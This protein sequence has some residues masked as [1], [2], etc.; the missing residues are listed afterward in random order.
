MPDG[1]ERTL[2]TAISSGGTP[3]QV[4]DMMVA[5]ATDHF[6]RDGGHILD[7]INKSFELLETDRLGT[8][9]VK[10]YRR[11]PVVSR[12]HRVQKNRN[13]WR[14]PNRFLFPLLND[15]FEELEALMTEGAGK[16][17]EGAEQLVEVLLGDDPF[18]TVEATQVG[19]Q[20]RSNTDRIDADACLCGGDADRP[21]FS[22]EKMSSGDWIA[23]LHTYTYANAL[24][25]CAKAWPH[26]WNLPAAFFMARW[27]STLN[28]WFNMPAAR[29]PQHRRETDTL[30]NRL[31]MKLLD[32]FVDLLNTQ[33]RADEAG[34]YLYRYL[35]LGHPRAAIIQKLGHILLRED[36]EFHSFQMLEAALHQMEETG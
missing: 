19:V 1:A 16:Q 36:A 13:R 26:R 24:H 31:R 29:L 9:G 25:Q 6:Y 22:H 33:A 32:G 10:F 2:L 23:V 17:W 4:C 27:Q 12:G 11:S 21:R 8:R 15:S 35:S 18:A 5:A 28:R 3:A 7:F 30:P 14:S 34:M 20:G